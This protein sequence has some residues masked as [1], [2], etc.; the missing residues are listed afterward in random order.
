M[1]PGKGLIDWIRLCR[2]KG[3]DLTGVGGVR[4]TV[5][6]E[7]LS[8]HNTEEDCWTA[9]RGRYLH[10]PIL[11]KLFNSSVFSCSAGVVYNITAYLSFH[12]GSVN[13][14]MKGAGIDCTALFNNVSRQSVFLGL[15]MSILTNACFVYRLTP[16]SGS[17][18]RLQLAS[19]V[20]WSCHHLRP[21]A[22]HV[23]WCLPQ[24]V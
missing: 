14:L 16:T 18:R 5:T 24:G 8:V 7:Q 13:E 23:S 17:V 10:S 15:C 1:P 20:I 11:C 9:V 19:L 2:G 6:P 21:S 12:P 4:I 3:T 22:L